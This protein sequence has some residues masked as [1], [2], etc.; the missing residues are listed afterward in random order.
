MPVAS[1]RRERRQPGEAGPA[2]LALEVARRSL[3]PCN[4]RSHPGESQQQEAERD[5]HPIEERGADGN[6]AA[7]HQLGENREQRAPKDGERDAH[8]QQVIEEEG[9]FP[10]DHGVELR[11]GL[12]QRPAGIKQREAEGTGDHQEREEEVADI[13]LG[14][15]VHARNH[16]RPGNERA[17]DAQQERA[18]DESRGSSA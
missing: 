7:P 10:A 8:E 11:V 9:S 3:P 18:H 13:R 14:K 2:K 5:V 17:E 1:R 4:E 16:A 12:E 15:A 6:L